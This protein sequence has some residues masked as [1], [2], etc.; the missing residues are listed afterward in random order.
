MIG[1]FYSGSF[2]KT[3]ITSYYK[4][5]GFYD[6]IIDKMEEVVDALKMFEVREQLVSISEA[7]G[8]FIGTDV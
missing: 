1:R 8:T 4:A 5:I 7:T 6:L 2:D 3:D